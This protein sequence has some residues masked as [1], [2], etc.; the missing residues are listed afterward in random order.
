MGCLMGT[1][2]EDALYLGCLWVSGGLR[3]AQGLSVRA[4]NK[5]ILNLVWPPAWGLTCPSSI[6][7][8]A[9][10]GPQGLG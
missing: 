9:K 5:R 3:E 2:E 10:A 8:Q 6:V 7:P 1:A 4:E